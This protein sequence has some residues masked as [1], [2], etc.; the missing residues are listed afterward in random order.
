MRRIIKVSLPKLH[1][2]QLK[3]QEALEKYRF[4]I[5]CFGRRAGKTTAG[6]VLCI[7]WAL[8][9]KGQN[10]WWVAPTR[11]IS[12]ISFRLFS[13][14]VPEYLL[15][16]INRSDLEVE[17]LNGSRIAWKSADRP[18]TL[19]GEGLNFLVI[20]EAAEVKEEVWHE[21]LRPALSDKEG[22]ALIMSRPH[23]ANWFYEEYLKGLPGPDGKPANPE[24][25]SL[26]LE[27]RE[28]P[29]FPQ[30]EWEAAKR[31]LP[32]AVF[33]Q[34]YRAIF[35]AGASAVFGSVD[36]ALVPEVVPAPGKR[37]MGV[38]PGRSRD[39]A[40]IV[41]LDLERNVVAC[42]AW[43]GL[44]LHLLAEIVERM[45]EEWNAEVIIDSHVIGQGLVD[46]LKMGPLG[47]RITP[48]PVKDKYVRR[49]L[50][51]DLALALDPAIS[52]PHIKIPAG[53]K[54]DFS[55]LPDGEA[56]AE[57]YR[58]LRDMDYHVSPSGEISYIPGVG[59]HDDLVIALALANYG[60][61]KHFSAATPLILRA[62]QMPRLSRVDV[63]K[64]RRIVERKYSRL[65][66][67][68]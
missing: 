10:I 48:Y 49:G 23:G 33:D 39:Y 16:N 20:D 45:S 35:T 67:G 15:K 37:F 1:P 19:L 61:K 51:E 26:H 58:E 34:E 22:S 13:K 9:W 18:Y 52:N 6:T 14:M 46:F 66:Y 40:A 43:R 50:I 65:R 8:R 11:G 38:D 59:G 3:I 31:Q 47:S 7:R 54:R 60:W 29:Y 5:A 32:K 17:F 36:E 12:K 55:G 68:L 2:G 63:F 25:C 56:L 53:E 42:K 64:T 57:L 44:S 21:I 30:S 62:S 4:V 27:S 28:N 24:Y 41:V